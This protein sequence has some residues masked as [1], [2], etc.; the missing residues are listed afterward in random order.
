MA[1]T[2]TIKLYICWLTGLNEIL[3]GE[4]RQFMGFTRGRYLYECSPATCVCLNVY[5]RVCMPACVCVCVC[6]RARACE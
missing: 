5:V 2:E 6:A 1:L 3:H 4:I